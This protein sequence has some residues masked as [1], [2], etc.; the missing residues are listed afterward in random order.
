MRGPVSLRLLLLICSVFDHLKTFD[1][2][3][4]SDSFIFF[5]VHRRRQE[6][7]FPLW[8][9][10]QNDGTEHQDT[11]QS[12]PQG[13]ALL[14]DEPSRQHRNHRFQAQH[15][16]GNGRIDPFLSDDLQGIS[17]P[18]GQCPGV[19]DRYPGDGKRMG[20]GNSFHS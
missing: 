1:A 10:G 2:V 19:Q 8:K 4:A 3:W 16:T 9:L 17:H 5:W 20:G 14:Q 11:A 15:Q 12:F 6:A 7:L 18:G 13:Q